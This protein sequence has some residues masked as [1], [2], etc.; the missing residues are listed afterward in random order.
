MGGTAVILGEWHIVRRR[1]HL[2]PGDMFGIVGVILL[3]V[4]AVSIDASRLMQS[5]IDLVQLRHDD[6]NNSTN[7][8]I[9]C[10]ETYFA[11]VTDLDHVTITPARRLINNVRLG[12]SDWRDWTNDFH[13]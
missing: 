8:N 11:L 5:H 6:G 9:R 2:D 4:T 3:F 1:H 10:F 7:Y 12:I 13:I